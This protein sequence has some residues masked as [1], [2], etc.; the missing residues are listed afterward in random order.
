MRRNGIAVAAAVVCLLALGSSGCSKE[1]TGPG[2]HPPVAQAGSDQLVMLAVTVDLSGSSSTDSDGDELTYAWSFT[3]RPTGSSAAFSSTTTVETSFVTDVAGDYVVLLTVSDGDEED[4]DTVTITA[5]P[6]MELTEDIT[7]ATTLTNIN[8]TAGQPDYLVNSVLN[9]SGSLT[10]APG[11]VI[12]F[13]AHAGFDIESGGSMGAVGTVTDSIYFR[14]QQRTPGYWYGLTFDSNNPGNIL[15]YVEVAD[16]GYGDYADV[17]VYADAQL[18]ITHSTLRGSSTQGLFVEDATLNDCES[19]RFV[20][21]TGSPVSIYAEL[22][23]VLD[24]TN[25]FS[26]T[27]GTA[28][29]EVR[30]GT[31]ATEQV[32][33]KLNAVCRFTAGT[34]LDAGVEIEPGAVLE[35]ASSVSFDVNATAY[36]QAIGTATDTIKFRG[37]V[38]SPGYWYGIYIMSNDINNTLTYTDIRNGGYGSYADV[39]LNGTAR[40]DISHSRLHRSST[41]GFYAETEGIFSFVQNTL[42]NNSGAPVSVDAEQV[43]MLNQDSVFSGGN[44]TEGIIVRGGTVVT[45]GTWYRQDVPYRISASVTADAGVTVQAGAQLRFSAQTFFDVGTNGFL[46]AVGT[47]TDSIRF[48]GN[49]DTPGYWYGI[50]VNSDHVSN[51]LQYAVVAD[52]GYGDYAD[53]YVYDSGRISITNC[54]LRDSSTYGIFGESGCVVTESN[55]TFARN[56]N[57]DVQIN[58]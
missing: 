6:M 11:V 21:N 4:T 37:V 8:P 29:I 42:V 38:D 47:V 24:S 9:V 22:L 39:Y 7:T 16:G 12:V 19:N 54:H 44:G 3:S 45:A 23:G 58:P 13:G 36:L 52:G 28:W 26:N 32:W 33:P 53:V 15:S 17:Y 14:G 40:V 18:T 35:F 31:V 1:S 55:N 46:L 56:A 5:Q 50:I 51:Q 34:D 43:R 48:V 57:G 2:N 41:Q 30:G 27:G 10:I 25:D 20:A 49:S